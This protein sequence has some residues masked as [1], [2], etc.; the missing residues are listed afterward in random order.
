MPWPE[1]SEIKPGRRDK[2]S[3][4]NVKLAVGML[5]IYQFLPFIVAGLLSAIVIGWVCWRTGLAPEVAFKQVDHA[6]IPL[7][8]LFGGLVAGAA[9]VWLACS[10]GGY[11]PPFRGR[12]DMNARRHGLETAAF[13]VAALLLAGAFM[14][15][16][17]YGPAAWFEMGGDP[18]YVLRHNR[19]AVSVYF[20]MGIL[21]QPVVEEFV[22]RGVFF[23]TLTRRYRVGLAALILSMIFVVMHAPRFYFLPI[24]VLP[25]SGLTVL[26][27]SARIRTGA[28]IA[29]MALHVA[30]NAVLAV[31]DALINR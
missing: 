9:V 21:F 18:V 24:A 2:S 30:Y 31:G 7:R 5:A 29:P 1:G 3:R 22:F 8:S 25:L 23:D 27:V 6:L 12:P 19:L 28:L 10:F 15:S 4:L 20:F 11:R 14:L 17:L 26:T 16:I 13:T